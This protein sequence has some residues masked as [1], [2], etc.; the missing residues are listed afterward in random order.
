MKIKCLNRLFPGSNKCTRDNTGD[1]PAGLRESLG[2]NGVWLHR[3]HITYWSHKWWH[4]SQWCIVNLAIIVSLRSVVV[5]LHICIL[6]CDAVVFHAHLMR[7]LMRIK[8][9]V[10]AH[11]RTSNVREWAH[12]RTSN[13]HEW[14]HLH[15]FWCAW[16]STL[17]LI[18]CAWMSTLTHIKMNVSLLI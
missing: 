6:K 14:S 15:T 4:C 11:L 8:M 12:L 17:K 18:K 1:G 7:S 10:S 13:V 16:V 3:S 2:L 5:C 9:C